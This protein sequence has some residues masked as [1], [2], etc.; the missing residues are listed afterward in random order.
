MKVRLEIIVGRN[1]RDG[2]EIVQWVEIT[3]DRHKF[4]S[5]LG[6]DIINTL[7]RSFNI[8]PIHVDMRVK[9]YAQAGTLRAPPSRF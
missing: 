2:G 3:D 5:D 7:R 8:S 6:S 9:P 1:P 4:P